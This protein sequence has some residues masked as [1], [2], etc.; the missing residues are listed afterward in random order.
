MVFKL[1]NDYGVKDI[2]NEL[3]GMFSGV[4]VN[5]R[6][7]ISIIFRDRFGIKPLYYT[8]NK[9]YF[10]AASEINSLLPFLKLFLVGGSNCLIANLYSNFF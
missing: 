9:N 7:N 2:I 5:A 8:K 10:L 4:Y 1:F 3:E 6:K